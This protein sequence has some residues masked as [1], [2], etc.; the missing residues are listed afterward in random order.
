VPIA[1]LI[2]LVQ[3]ILNLFKSKKTVASFTSESVRLTPTVIMV[4]C[5]GCNINFGSPTVTQARNHDMLDIKCV[6][7]ESVLPLDRNIY[8]LPEYDITCPYCGQRS[9]GSVILHTLAPPK[10]PQE[11]R[12]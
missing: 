7:C 5:T 6:K 2:P 9:F 12:D 4:N 1:S 8:Q 3:S 10:P 11:D